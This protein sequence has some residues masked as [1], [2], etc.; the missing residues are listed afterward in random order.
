MW[1]TFSQ[2]RNVSPW[3]DS[4]TITEQAGQFV[5]IEVEGI[6]DVREANDRFEKFTGEHLHRYD[7]SCGSSYDD[8]DIHRP[9]RAVDTDTARHRPTVLGRNI[10]DPEDLNTFLYLYY[11]TLSC[12]EAG[13][14]I[15]M[16]F[17][18]GESKKL[19]FSEEDFKSARAAWAETRPKMWATLVN[20]HGAFEP[21]VVVLQSYRT[22]AR[23]YWYDVEGNF[24]GELVPEGEN[25]TR[26]DGPAYY[27][28]ATKGKVEEYVSGALRVFKAAVAGAEAEMKKIRGTRG[29]TKEHALGANRALCLIKQAL[30]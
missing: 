7:S 13:L 8:E 24:G 22:R 20:N 16:Y 21:R 4:F 23:D 29:T 25:A 3:R 14:Q 6:R 15:N 2:D 27:A 10:E 28:S 12:G 18:N 9:W 5:L 11:S 30:N 19:T 17:A 1:F 26:D